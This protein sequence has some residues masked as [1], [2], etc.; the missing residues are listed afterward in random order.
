MHRKRQS[1][2]V[3]LA[4]LIASAITLGM[5]VLTIV[6]IGQSFRGMEKAKVSAAGAAARQL[7]V[8][9]DDRIHHRATVHRPSSA[10]PRQPRRCTDAGATP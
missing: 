8:S 4:L 9:V 3:S 6:L 2:Q 1:A 7:A 5:L 10:Q